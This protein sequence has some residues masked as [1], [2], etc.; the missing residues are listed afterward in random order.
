VTTSV[1]T[2]GV[3]TIQAAAKAPVAPFRLDGVLLKG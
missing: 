3:A 1:C 2:R